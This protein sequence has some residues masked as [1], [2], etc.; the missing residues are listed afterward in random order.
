M[1]FHKELE[2]VDVK[3]K[4]VGRYRDFSKYVVEVEH[5]DAS[6]KGYLIDP[7]GY[8]QCTQGKTIFLT[9]QNGSLVVE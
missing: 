7:V 3:G 5:E 8:E 9:T 2:T 4:I 1:L 6:R